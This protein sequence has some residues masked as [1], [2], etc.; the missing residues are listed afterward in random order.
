M[1]LLVKLYRFLARRTDSKFNKVILHRLYMSRANRPPL[2]IT[3]IGKL[4]EKKDG[5][6]AVIVGNVT[7]EDAQSVW[8]N[9]QTERQAGRQASR[10]VD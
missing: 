2:S 5:K 8:L 1:K 6:I 10:H 7:G 9:R 3:R 4:M